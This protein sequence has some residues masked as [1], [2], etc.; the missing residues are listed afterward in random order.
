VHDLPSAEMT[1]PSVTSDRLILAPS[2]SR[3]ANSSRGSSVLTPVPPPIGAVL[4][5]PARSLPA[6]STRWSRGGAPASGEQE[7]WWCWLFAWWCERGQMERRA[8]PREER[9]FPA[10]LP[11]LRAHSPRDTSAAKDEASSTTCSLKPATPRDVRRRRR[12]EGERGW[13]K[14]K[15]LSYF[16]HVWLVTTTFCRT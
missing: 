4:V 15:H 12:K 16:P 10:V 13:K 14:R 3:A 2:L 8:W 7:R 6:K 1:F 9:G 11:T 5:A